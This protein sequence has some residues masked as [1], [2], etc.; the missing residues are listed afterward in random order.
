MVVNLRII[1]STSKSQN[2]ESDNS[3]I[4]PSPIDEA[5]KA[6]LPADEAEWTVQSALQVLG[7]FM[8][9]FNSSVSLFIQIPF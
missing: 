6:A 9:L 1:A 5:E 4:A 3:T 8:L 2:M 7:G